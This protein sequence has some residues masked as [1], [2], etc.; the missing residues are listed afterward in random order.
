MNRDTIME[1]SVTSSASLSKPIEIYA[2][3]DPLCSKCWA[4]QPLLRKLQVEYERYFTLRIVLRSSLPKMNL[5]NL[6]NRC[7]DVKSCDKTHPSFPSIAMKAAEFQGKRAGFRFLSKLFEY[8]YLKSRNVLSFSVLVE[9]AEKLGLDVDEFIL[10][11]S[12]HNVLRSLQVDLYLANEMEVD[13]A[14]SFVFF[15]EN[16]EDEGLKVNGLHSYEIYEQILEEM[17]GYPIDPDTPPPLD[18]LFKRFDSLATKEV[19]EIYHISEKSAE[20]ELKKQLLQQNLERQPFNNVTL[21]RKR[22]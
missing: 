15:N 4:L 5:T 20:R 21:W 12:S 19:A 2:F 1:N 22:Q 13:I 6:S 7:D 10:D 14:P 18:D 11:F 9:I 17:V 3:V 16:I 8:T